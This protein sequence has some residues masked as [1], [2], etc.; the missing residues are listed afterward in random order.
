MRLVVRDPEA[1][2]GL[3]GDLLER[4]ELPGRGVPSSPRLWICLLRLATGYAGARAHAWV[5]AHR[6]PVRRLI[7]H[8]GDSGLSDLLQDLRFATRTLVRSYGFT[9]AAVIT[10]AIGIGAATAMFG[11]LNAALLRAL[12]YEDPERLVLVRTTF[13]GNVNNTTSSP[14]YDDVREQNDVFDTF[15]LACLI[16]ATRATGVEPVAVLREE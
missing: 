5:V 15:A 2:E 7:P 14:D 1:R 12:P 8:P 11:V 9:A 13:D 16:P 6:L 10:L 3:V 4:A